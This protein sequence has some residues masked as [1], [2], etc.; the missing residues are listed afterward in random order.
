MTKILPAIAFLLASGTAVLAAPPAPPPGPPAPKILVI[1]RQAIL[2]A[3]KVGQD[4]Q[5]QIQA[6]ATQAQ[7]ELAAQGKALQAE[8]QALQ[9]QVAILAPDA[10]QQKVNAFQAKEAAAQASAQRREAALR[11]TAAKAEQT[12][13]AAFLPIVQA[14][15]QQRGANMLLDKNSVVFVNV[16]GLDITPEA[17]QALNQKMPS[18]KLTLENPPPGAVLPA[19]AAH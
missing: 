15:M 3:S 6:F 13:S 12:I 5:R 2:Q 16:Q 8:G 18:L 4:V 17:I 7:N 14:M 9:Q 19:P 10:K 1:D 11:Y